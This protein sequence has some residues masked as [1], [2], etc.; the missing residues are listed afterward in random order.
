MVVNISEL[1][2]KHITY[3]RR[4]RDAETS[5][6][7][8]QRP[9]SR[10]RRTRRECDSVRERDSLVAEPGGDGECSSRTALRE[11]RRHDVWLWRKK[12]RFV[13]LYEGGELALLAGEI[14]SRLHW[15]AVVEDERVG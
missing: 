10:W 1:Q 15:R 9:S 12:T 7:N 4:D 8:E 3:A 2:T 6:C 14:S 5:V 11:S 13:T